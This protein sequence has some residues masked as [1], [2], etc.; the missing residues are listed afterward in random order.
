M[1]TFKAI[2]IPNNRRKDG[3]Y[4]VKIRVTFGGKVR[5]L[6][7]NLVCKP[8]DLTRSCHIKSAFILNKAEET[9]SQMRR[10]AADIP[11]FELEGKDVDWVVAYIKAKLTSRNFQLNFFDFADEYMTRFGDSTRK[12]YISA[13]N[14]FE[15]FL[16]CRICDI[17]S[18]TKTMIQ[19]FVDYVN[20]EDK[21]VY[22]AK[23]GKAVPSSKKKKA[24]TAA[25]MYT[26]KLSTIFKAAKDK[27]ND[28]DEDVL[29]IPR[30]P[31]AR[32]QVEKSDSDGQN[33]LGV[34]LMQR[35]I[36]AVPDNSAQARALNTF[37]L[38]FC[39]MGANMADL[40][41]AKTL[42]G[43]SWRYNRQ[44]TSSRRRD[45]AEMVVALPEPALVY[46]NRLKSTNKWLLGLIHDKNHTKDIATTAVN[47]CLKRWCK[48][49]GVDRFTFYAARHTW[50]SLARKAGVEKALVDECL[51]HKGD[52]DL[53]DV[54][55]E[56]DW[57]LMAEANRKV[58]ALFTW[59]EE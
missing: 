10:V 16:G 5:R 40:Y 24:G 42:K 35:I 32:V 23:T 38:S 56:R 21:V 49:N 59:P 51:A 20:N 28:E 17:N 27:Y 6:P 22:D 30:S 53:V 18:I 36:D 4:P 41:A 19:D 34:E 54:Y 1:I 46:I 39:L 52:F 2:V 12:T 37:L 45:K 26:S 48:Q 58:L 50:A 7:T 11:L 57:D 14:A 15:R 9:I 13:V 31:F 43:D 8:E 44:K 47:G 3:T 33:N 29:L 25:Y 55:A